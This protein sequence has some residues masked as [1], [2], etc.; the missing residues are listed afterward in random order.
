M[1]ALYVYLHRGGFLFG[2]L[3]TEDATC[4]RI[5]IDTGVTVFAVCYHHT[6]EYRY[7]ADFPIKIEKV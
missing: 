4:T 7:P 6:L 2:N 1:T 3:N 5:G